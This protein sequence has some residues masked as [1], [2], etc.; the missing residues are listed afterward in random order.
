[1]SPINVE[2]PAETA[3]LHAELDALQAEV[4]VLMAGHKG[5]RP[6]ELIR[7][8]VPL[9][10]LDRLAELGVDVV[11]LGIIKPRTLTH[12]RSR[13]QALST[14]EGDRLYRAGKILLLAEDVFGSREKAAKW[15]QKPRKALG[16]ISALEAIVTTPGYEAAEEQLE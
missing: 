4:A 5:G 9:E 3:K 12:R 11:D 13:G 1:M 14:E 2:E 10:A 15:L 6:D 16:G 7:E 8:G